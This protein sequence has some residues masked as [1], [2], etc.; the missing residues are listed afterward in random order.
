MAAERL[1]V[2]GDAS[3][4]NAVG[5]LAAPFKNNVPLIE[6]KGSFGSRTIP[7][8]I[9]APRYTEV[10]R[11]KAA[12]A[13]LYNDLPLV[14]L[15]EN[16]D[17]SNLMPINFL[18]LIP[19]VLLNGVEGVAVGFSTKIL[20]RALPDLIAATKAALAGKKFAEPMPKFERYDLDIRS[21]SASQYEFTGKVKIENTSTLRV[22]E[23]PP[24]TSLEDFKKRLIGME[25]ED[26]IVN[27]LDGSASRIDIEIQMKRGSLR[28][29][30]DVKALD[31]LKL[32]E[33]VTER[34]TVV[35][36][37][38]ENIMVYETASALI[39]DFVKWRLGFYEQRYQKYLDDENY[40]LLYWKLLRALFK[41]GFTKKLGTFPDRTNMETEVTAVANKA[42]LSTDERHIDRA[43]SLP[44]YRWTRDFEA[45]VERKI[46]E[47]ESRIIDYTDIL[48]KPERRKAIY[49]SEL[50]DLAKLKL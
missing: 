36:W 23:L 29:W 27:F 46:S 7:D 17:G 3:S 50:D 9:G 19:L 15:T 5:Y 31:F 13:F 10:R 37:K 20:P 40:E 8:G 38:S 47:M 14:P 28:G 18:P 24:G 11:A 48:A 22:T 35:D 33:K 4:G 30:T 16:Y 43:V 32:R 2:H 49:L 42:R 25:E 45:E 1:Y 21:L 6:G 12:E 34:L 44:T 39:R 41:A 26:L